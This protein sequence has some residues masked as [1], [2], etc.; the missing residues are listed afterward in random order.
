MKKERYLIMERVSPVRIRRQ[1][2]GLRMPFA[3]TVVRKQA[4]GLRTWKVMDGRDVANITPHFVSNRNDTQLHS[5]VLHTAREPV[6]QF[7]E[8][9]G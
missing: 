9:R 3:A 7:S 5:T 8:D 6:H 4:G 2:A 1:V